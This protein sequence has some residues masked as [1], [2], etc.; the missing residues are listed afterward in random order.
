MDIIYS[1]HASDQVSCKLPISHQKLIL[2]KFWSNLVCLDK[3][4]K[5]MLVCNRVFYYFLLFPSLLLFHS[6]FGDIYIYTSQHLFHLWA[7]VWFYLFLD[8]LFGLAYV[9]NIFDYI[10]ISLPEPRRTTSHRSGKLHTQRQEDIK[11]K[12][13]VLSWPGS[14]NLQERSVS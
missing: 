3:N 2:P 12:L 14:C 11:N 4:T 10:R 6:I 1:W 9:I 8:N 7:T 13:A 5:C